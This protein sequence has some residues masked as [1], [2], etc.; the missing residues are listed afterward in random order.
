[1]SRLLCQTELPRR[2]VSSSSIKELANLAEALCIY[3]IDCE[4]GE[5]PRQI[6]KYYSTTDFHIEVKIYAT[7]S[8]RTDPEN[9]PDLFHA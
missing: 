5:L 9:S 7:K 4:G 1:M 3:L 8:D 2:K 6:S